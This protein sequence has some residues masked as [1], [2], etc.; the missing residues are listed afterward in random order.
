MNN[1]DV[2]EAARRRIVGLVDDDN[3]RTE[4]P[5]CPGW[6]VKDVVA[7]LA[8]SLHAYAT[9]DVQ[10][11]SSPQ[12]GEGQ[13]AERA[14]KSLTECFAEWDEHA[15]AAAPDFFDSQL[16]PVAVADILA[17]EHDI[18]TALGRPGH[19][20]DEGITAAVQMGLAF[21]GRKVQSAHVPAFRVVTEDIDTV[22]GEGA[23]EATLRT[24][25]FELFRSLHGRRTP[26]QVRSLDWEGDPEPWMEVFFLFGPADSAVE[27]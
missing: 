26:N 20:D 23:P 3:A 13:V 15:A 11:A 18:R 9:G 7:H 2:Y 10:G 8:G 5:T 17:H 21:T 6:T 4:V 12:W 25:T 1:V 14:D 22:V 19:R 24:S 27:E 16:A